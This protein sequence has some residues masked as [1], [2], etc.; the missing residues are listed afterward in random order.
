MWKRHE[1][2]PESVRLFLLHH[3]ALSGEVLGVRSCL[4]ACLRNKLSVS[5]K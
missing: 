1:F 2:H 4:L 5:W 3:T